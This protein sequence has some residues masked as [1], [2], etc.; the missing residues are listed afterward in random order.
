MFVTRGNKRN[1]GY[2]NEE[3]T[4]E[5][6]DDADNNS[7]NIS[8]G[9]SV[10]PTQKRSKQKETDDTSIPRILDGK[11]FQIVSRD[12]TSVEAKCTECQKQRKGDTKSTGNF[13]TH[14][15]KEHPD[16][17]KEIKL[18]KKQ[19]ND[20]QTSTVPSLKQTTLPRFVTI[21]AQIVRV[22]FSFYHFTSYIR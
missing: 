21:P 13:M 8:T 4:T 18:Y 22:V 19:K 1:H 2:I 9:Q 20:T 12:K 15:V 11:Y 16:L 10:E 14:Y 6:T 5:N 3:N 7:E 17:V